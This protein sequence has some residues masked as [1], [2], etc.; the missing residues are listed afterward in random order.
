MKKHLPFLVLICL[1]L[2]F[3]V[4]AQKAYVPDDN[5]EQALIDLGFDDVLDDS[6]LV[7]N[8]KNVSELNVSNK[9][10]NDL[11]G[12]KSFTNLMTLDCSRNNIKFLDVSNL[13]SLRS[14]TCN[15]NGMNKIKLDGLVALNDLFCF[16]NNLK[17]LNLKDSRAIYRLFCQYNQITSLN[18][19]N[20]N[21]AFVN[22]A[23]NNLTYLNLAIMS[24]SNT[25]VTSSGNPDLSCITVFDVNAAWNAD[26][27]FSKAENAS[28][29]L[30]CPSAPET[31]ITDANFEQVLIDL[32][33]DEVLDGKVLTDVIKDIT[34]LDLSKNSNITNFAGIEAFKNLTTLNLS[35]TTANVIN[36]NGKTDADIYYTEDVVDNALTNLT[37]LNVSNSNLIQLD[38]RGL[39]GLQNGTMIATNNANLNCILVDDKDAAATYSLWQKD[40]NARYG[41]TCNEPTSVNNVNANMVKIYPNPSNG[42]FTIE[43][44]E[45]ALVN[46]YDTAGKLVFTK[47][48]N[49]GNQNI[50]IDSA[51]NIYYL[52][53]VSKSGVKTQKVIVQ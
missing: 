32:G 16:G 24:L 48:V 11:T 3:T 17:V 44:T 29:S 25:N 52:Q 40:A 20:V 33:Y 26:G 23:Y 46:I 45:D 41:T 50:K 28:Y 7:N 14:L 53:I 34:E 1:L 15:A 10:I 6:V 4:N 30:N 35:G 42:E 5:F 12:I 36:L 43:L 39:T 51:K 47:Q 37:Y 22:C 38:L 27:W 18:L 8:I 31:N 21:P 2:A 9:S 49:S 13:A 19:S